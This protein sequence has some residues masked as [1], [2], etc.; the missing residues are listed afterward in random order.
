M[1]SKNWF[2]LSISK[3][4]F[5]FQ[6]LQQDTRILFQAS[7]IRRSKINAKPHRNL[8]RN[9]LLKNELLQIKQV[10]ICLLHLVRRIDHKS[11][12]D[13]RTVGSVPDAEHADDAAEV[14]RILVAVGT[15]RELVLLSSFLR[16]TKLNFHTKTYHATHSSPPLCHVKLLTW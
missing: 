9:E 13:I 7:K 8:T 10:G 15:R 16:S 11:A 14:E 12:N 6:T 2:T 4:I 3:W 1:V 5:L